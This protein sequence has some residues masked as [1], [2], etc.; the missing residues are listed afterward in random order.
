MDELIVLLIRLIIKAFDKGGEGSRQEQA[1]RQWEQQQA[2]ELQHREW[3]ARRQ[4]WEREQAEQLARGGRPSGGPF[5]PA[6]LPPA[7]PRAESSTTGRR[8]KG[9]SAPLV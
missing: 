4:Q 7:A 8:R 5:Q 9:K 3:L 6:P 2:W 1:R